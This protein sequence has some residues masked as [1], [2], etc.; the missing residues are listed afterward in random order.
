MK[1]VKIRVLQ[2]QQVNRKITNWERNETLIFPGKTL[3]KVPGLDIYGIGPTGQK[4]CLHLHQIYPYLYVPY[5]GNLK[6]SQQVAL[7]L[8]L[9][10]L[11]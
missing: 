7:Q 11:Y 8:A 5:T 4:M 3:Y 2:I 1:K 10:Q 9:V 6:E